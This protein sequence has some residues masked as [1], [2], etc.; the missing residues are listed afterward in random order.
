MSSHLRVLVGFVAAVILD[1]RAFAAAG[2][3]LV[4]DA[5]QLPP[6]LHL[7]DTLQ[8]FRQRGLDLLIVDAAVQSAVADV[9]VA[10]AVP[11]PGLSLGYGRS[12]AKRLGD[13]GADPPTSDSWVIEKDPVLSAGL[14][15]QAALQSIVFGKRGLRIDV[16]QA[17]VNA[18]RLTRV[19]AQRTLESQLKQAF[20]IALIARDTLKFA[21]EVQRASTQ[22]LDLTQTRYNAGAISEADLA[23]IRTAKLESDQAVD[24]TFQNYRLAQ[25]AL[26]FLLGVRSTVPDFEVEEPELLHYVLPQALSNVTKDALLESAFANRPD[27][28][29]I[30]FQQQRAQ[31][32]IGL[33]KRMRIP[34][35]ALNLTYTQQGTV[36]GQAITPPTLTFGIS[37]PLPIFYQQQGEI[38][39]AEAD[40]RT[41]A[42]QYA[43]VQAQV[44]ADIESGYAAFTSSE[45][46]VKRMESGGLLASARRA[47]DLVSI[48]YQKGA[49]SLLEFLDAQRTYIGTY[50]EYLQDLTIYW[51]AV[52]KLEQA[53][54]TRLQ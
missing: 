52:F 18:A 5:V 29:A 8:I 32:S 6:V 27:L 1:A 12:F 42:L 19:D 24:T 40:Y 28:R 13:P 26:A 9:R 54:G 10:G 21:R 44:A 36:E 39:K 46:L 51:T 48:Q 34:D 43:K 3:P 53:V 11:N 49:A 23:R 38:Q 15:D 25:V 30:R 50:V 41:Q 45:Q 7:E 22:M 2:E 4:P 14:S 31:S 33:A 16:A 47:R 37:A 17:A 20:L 35:I